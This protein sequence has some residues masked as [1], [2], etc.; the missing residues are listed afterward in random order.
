MHES[1]PSRELTSPTHTASMAGDQGAASV[2]RTEIALLRQ[3][4]ARLR[5]ETRFARVL[6]GLA[7]AALGIGLLAMRDPQAATVIQTKRLEIVDEKGRVTMVATSTP[8]G[9]RLDLWDASGS[10][11]ARLG[12]N[13][14]GGDFI[15]WNRE[16]KPVFGA[17]AQMNGGRAEIG[18]SLGRV[19][20]VVEAGPNGG[21]TS[22]YD[23][24]GD[25]VVAAG[26]FTSGGAIRVADAK[27]ADAVL[28]E[29]TETGGGVSVTAPDGAVFGRL[30]A[31][32][33]GGE[34]DL[35]SK[36][37]ANRVNASA[38][39]SDAAVIA[40]GAAGSSKIGGSKVGGG[41]DLLNEKGD[42]IVSLESNEGGGL[43]V[44]RAG[45]ER[46]VASLGASSS[47]TRGGLLQVYNAQ[48]SPVFAAA[49]TSDGAGRLAIGTAGGV[50]TL[51]AEA[52]KE[53]GASIS[54]VRGG[55]RALAFVAAA[56][57]G[58]MNIFSAAGAPSVVAGNADDASGG[59]V[60][61]RS[62]EGKDLALLGVD[63]KGGGNVVLFNKDATERKTLAGPR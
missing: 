37:G 29:A 51:T 48:Q 41:I 60:L 22:L 8:Q 62:A 33:T 56:N 44:C 58:L 11:T 54:L 42:R 47:G 55:K 23:P 36:S 59:V 38:K 61:L 24:N 16:G 31:G 6:G 32:E 46:P 4:I 3:E 45:G 18:T 10:N 35:A 17:Y 2:S 39:D 53:D 21:R 9:G 63:D 28:I 57:G 50:A 15:L 12:A 40:L 43:L 13:D 52:G 27:N 14:L 26:A 19:G 25:P 20:A 30:R 1:T 49:V 5:G 7:A 34:F